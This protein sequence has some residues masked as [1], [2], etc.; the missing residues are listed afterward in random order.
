MRAPCWATKQS[1]NSMYQQA[2]K[3]LV[4]DVALVPVYRPVLVAMV[5]PNIKGPMFE[6]DKNGTRTWELAIASPAVNR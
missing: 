6:P 1:A 4:E 5:K 3:L 2:E